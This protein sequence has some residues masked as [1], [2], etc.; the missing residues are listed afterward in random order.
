M[1]EIPKRQRFFGEGEVSGE[2]QTKE[3]ATHAC[4]TSGEAAFGSFP[5]LRR[6]TGWYKRTFYSEV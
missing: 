1:R 3:R 2:K 6:K 5:R 4:E